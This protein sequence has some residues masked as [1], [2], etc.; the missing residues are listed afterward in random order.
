M[1]SRL[2]VAA[3]LLTVAAVACA[4]GAGN[5][6]GE[7]VDRDD[8]SSGE[9]AASSSTGSSAISSAATAGSG[10]AGGAGSGGA[11]GSACEESPCK[12]VAPQC[13]CGGGEQ[14][15]LAP[16]AGRAC[17]PEGDVP[18]K[19]LC[20]QSAACEPGG[21][22][23]TVGSTSMCAKACDDDAQ[24]G[25][26]GG[27]CIRE[28]GDGNGGS[29]PDVLLCTES[30]DPSTS[31][32]CPA[33]GTGCQVG[34]EEAGQGRFFTVCAASGAGKQGASCMSNAD[35]A[36]SFGCFSD[37]ISKQCMKNCK[38]A[39]PSCPAGTQCYEITVEMEL[40]MIGNEQY[41]ACS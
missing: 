30:C 38:V 36:P 26:P 11:G 32:G 41:G 15:G 24:C 10:G 16:S 19:E 27:L 23:V 21:L 35:C 8:A 4:T 28:L 7:D 20:G 18:W 17:V 25:G 9:V 2:H 40:V 34:R 33:K 5:F 13:G 22:C 39:S 37:G 6:D 1:R 31:A 29:I 12:L 3:G 14:C